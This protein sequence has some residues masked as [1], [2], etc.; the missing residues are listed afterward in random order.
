MILDFVF[1]GEDYV[2]K[3]PDVQE[4]VGEHTIS[5]HLNLM[6]GNTP[7]PATRSVTSKSSAATH[8][9]GCFRAKSR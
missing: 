5:S 9:T 1:G 7:S 8:P 3:C 6:A 4:N 2:R